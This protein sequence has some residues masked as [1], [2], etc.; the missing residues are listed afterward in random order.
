MTEKKFAI[1]LSEKRGEDALKEISLKIKSVF[2]RSIKYVIVLFT[3]HYQAQNITK[4]LKFTLNPQ[5]LFGITSPLLIYEGRLI[6]RG[7]IA[8]CIN[9]KEAQLKGAI[10]EEG[11]DALNPWLDNTLKEMGG[12]KKALFS[13]LSG[14]GQRL[15]Y[16]KELNSALIKGIDIVGA[17]YIK[18]GT[19]KYL[20]IADS[21]SE[22]ALNI[23]SKGLNIDVFNLGGYLPLGKPFTITKVGESEI[24]TEINNEPAINIYRNYLE[25]KFN[26]FKK[27]RLFVYYPLG[28][29]ERGRM[30]LVSI[31]DYL[32]DGSLVY[33][34]GVK[35]GDSAQL[36]LLNQTSLL[37]SLKKRLNI[38]GKSSEGAVFMI[39]S[40][41][42]KK[43]ST[44][45]AAEE[46]L[47]WIRKYLGEQLSFFGIYTDYSL[48]S[49]K[50][51]K[52]IGIESANSLITLW[53]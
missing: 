42:R 2:P 3:P 46:E 31:R 24:I 52:E 22:G 6:E 16:L 7:I 9:K 29:K 26:T 14:Y 44:T 17:G 25:E 50:K 18:K 10:L 35:E 40:L 39:N 38:I 33:T 5:G 27:K 32:E 48:T 4:T 51:T 34:G 1:A 15:S 11:N 30:R 23:I 37:E 45:S 12:K 21:A 53:T 19:A 28:I 43:I 13:L 36:L 49:D 8:W 47:R 41:I 20:Q